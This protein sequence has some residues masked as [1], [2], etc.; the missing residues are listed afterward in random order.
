M[1]S[2]LKCSVRRFKVLGFGS[3]LR[4]A[5][6]RG[7]DRLGWRVTGTKLYAVTARKVQRPL[8]VRPFTSDIHVFRQ[9]FANLEY[10]PVESLVSPD[11]ALIVDCGANVGMSGAYLLSEFPNARLIAV[12]PDRTNCELLRLNLKQFGERAIVVEGAIWPVQET[13]KIS[14]SVFRDGQHWSRQVERSEADGLGIRGY[15]INEILEIA[16]SDSIW[17]LKV[18]IERAEIE[19][20]GRQCE[21]WIDKVNNIAIELHDEECENVFF[22]GIGDRPWR[23]ERHGDLTFCF[24]DSVLQSE[25][26]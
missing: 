10:K 2:R 14:D 16:S 20:F 26:K 18:D 9:V 22:R 4:Y 25:A 23:I 6:R 21:S 7:L 5:L 15:T 12:E 8:F 3:W 1:F 24:Q 11:S 17:L 13:L 19:L